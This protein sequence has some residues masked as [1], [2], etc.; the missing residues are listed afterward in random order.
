[1]GFTGFMGA[2]G[3]AALAAAAEASP[4]APAI[5]DCPEADAVH[6]REQNNAGKRI[7]MEKSTTLQLRRGGALRLS[8]G[9]AGNFS[10]ATKTY[11]PNRASCAQTLSEHGTKA[12]TWLMTRLYS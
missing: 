2:S 12:W 8:L 11:A 9:L 5:D 4:L 3:V 6:S 7:L 1:M 10:D